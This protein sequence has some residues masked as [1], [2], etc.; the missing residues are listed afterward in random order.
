MGHI[1]EFQQTQYIVFSI[2]KELYSFSI[3]EV[4]EILRLSEVT[5]VPGI[6]DVIEGVI[7]LRGAIIPIVNLHKRLQMERPATTKKNRIVIVRGEN[8]QIG[9]IVEEV[10]MVTHFDENDVEPT[11]GHQREEDLFLNFAKFDN[12]VIGILNLQKL[13]YGFEK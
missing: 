11:S 5:P 9:L 1:N 7:N 10:R 4:V 8:G 12:Q 3:A 13:L 6:H 2:N